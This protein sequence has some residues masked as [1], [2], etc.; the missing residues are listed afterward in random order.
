MVP[1][2]CNLLPEG[3]PSL[4]NSDGYVSIE[5]KWGREKMQIVPY[6]LPKLASILIL[7]R[8]GSAEL[9]AQGPRL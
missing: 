6:R 1:R 5:S 8:N 9:L 3:Q 2:H 7:L 4:P